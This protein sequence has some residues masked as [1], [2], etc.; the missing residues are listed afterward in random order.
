MSADREGCCL[1]IAPVYDPCW[2]VAVSFLA[3]L[4]ATRALQIHAC[5]PSK[6]IHACLQIEP[7]LLEDGV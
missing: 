4:I 5:M 1:L 6:S 2:L 7:R 3:V